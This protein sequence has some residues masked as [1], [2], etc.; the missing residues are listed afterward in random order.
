[1][2]QLRQLLT[3][4]LSRFLK[5]LASVR[6]LPPFRL[7]N[8]LFAFLRRRTCAKSHRSTA[9]QHRPPTPSHNG[10]FCAM[11][12]PLSESSGVR[13]G[14]QPS[15]VDLPSISVRSPTNNNT[16]SHAPASCDS[17]D[18]IA[19]MAGNETYDEPNDI[20][21]T[22]SQVATHSIHLSSPTT[23]SYLT[24]HGGHTLG[25]DISTHPPQLP[26][27]KVTVGTPVTTSFPYTTHLHPTGSYQSLVNSS[28]LSVCSSQNSVGRGSFRKHRGPT[29]VPRTP[30]Y[31]KDATASLIPRTVGP[32]GSAPFQRDVAQ[33]SADDSDQAGA[34]T[35]RVFPM[36]TNGVY[37]YEYRMTR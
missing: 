30:V 35:P 17:R 7:L 37:R 18:S 6:G 12:A 5:F 13:E 20:N 36:S 25:S 11:S 3:Q 33:P 9:H 8:Y 21:C 15:P 32:G 10:V 24:P 28:Q 27:P 26:T 4:F 23:M 31:D 16:T 22:I 29:A 34:P 14:G 2:A 19:L 1:M